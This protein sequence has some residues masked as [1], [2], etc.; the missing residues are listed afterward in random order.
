[1][2]DNLTTLP[3]GGVLGL[4]AAGD[5]LSE[6]LVLFCGPTPGGGLFDPDPVVTGTWGVH[7]V[8]LD[9]PGYG[10]TP[11]LD[12]HAPADEAS[13]QARAD[14]LA[15]YLI[16]A[17]RTA[18]QSNATA[19]GP[20]GVVGWGTGGMVALSLAARHPELVDRV[21]TVHTPAPGGAVFDAERV[22]GAPFG[23]SALGI[24][25]DDPALRRPGLRNRLGRLL[26]QAGAQGDAGVIADRRALEEAGWAE[27][28]GAIRAEVRLI[29]ADDMTDVDR[30]D[31][32]W[33]RSR[34]PSARVV[35]V[36]SGGPLVI[37]TQWARILEHVAP[38]HGGL[39]ERTR[40]PQGAD[41]RR[42]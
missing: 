25:A 42:G 38:D 8:S 2:A 19:F 32:V 26:E 23:P 10:A 30:E 16:G 40:D 18:R 22:G 1:M 15:G 3:S 6:R 34:I 21:A 9:R 24:A 14:D 27:E 7:L 36:S 39:S 20:V 28:L 33:Y 5:P 31:G 17:G 11:A 4:S 35:R 12:E 13:I 41:A 29:S 37:A